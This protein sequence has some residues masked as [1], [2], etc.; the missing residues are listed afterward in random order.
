MV[1]IC[2]LGA[3]IANALTS[4]FQRMGVEDAPADSTLT[5]G[6][7]AHALRRGVWIFGFVLM[8]FSFLFQAV[9]LHFGQ[10]SEVQPV[11]T[12]E[13]LFLV[14]VLAVW[15]RFNVGTREYVGA[16]AAGAGLAGFLVFADPRAGNAPPPS[17]EWA[18]AAAACG[19]A[20]A[21]AVVMALRGP[22]WW[23]AALFGTASA[24]GFAFTAALTKAVGNYF[25]QDW[26]S[27]FKHPQ[28]YGLAIFGVA[29]VFLAQ[30][31]FHAG[32]IVASQSTIVLV[33]PLVSIIIGICLFGDNL[34][35][36]GAWGP[37]EALSLLVLFAGAFSLVNS[38]L[39][40]G[41]KGV[42]AED[43][44]LLGGRRRQEPVPHPMSPPPL[45]HS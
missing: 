31:A 40:R 33:D 37:L 17:W 44:E 19:G 8:V 2:A 4:V 7:M 11:L 43:T 6:L 1:F 29:S 24:I 20:M 21:V 16:L 42:E 5:L 39:V 25:A 45:G 22:R 14:F 41:I 12:L 23:R 15:F 34:R 10:L 9:A 38:P 26:V 27:I 30:N 3:A 28:T 13:L 36:N 18:T 35:T 32:P